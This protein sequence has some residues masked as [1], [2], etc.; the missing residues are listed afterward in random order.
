[1]V[2]RVF[3]SF[4]FVLTLAAAAWAQAPQRVVFW[5]GDAG[6]GYKSRAFTAEDKVAC[7]VVTTERGP[8]NSLTVNGVGLTVAFVEEGE[9]HVVAA[10]ITNSTDEFV[11]FDADVWGAAH[12]KSREDYSARRKPIVAETSIPT[13]LIIKSMAY[14]TKLGN[15]LDTFIAEGE[16]TSGT[17]SVRRP[18]GTVVRTRVIVP[19]ENAKEAAA[20]NTEIRSENTANEQRR[21]RRDALTT[22]TVPAKSFVKGLVYFRLVEKAGFVLFSFRVGDVNYVFRL[23]RSNK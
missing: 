18:D 6:C 7:S 1:M 4:L 12:F 15:S 10:R 9:Y 19:D 8:V 3:V 2:M 13:S 16:K 17:K 20:R 21:I 14:G 23:P 22:K 5:S 11:M